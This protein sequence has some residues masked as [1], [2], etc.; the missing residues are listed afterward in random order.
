ML[1][2][3]ARRE[4]LVHL[5][6][7]ANRADEPPQIVAN[8]NRLRLEV[9]FRPRTDL[10]SGLS[11]ALDYSENTRTASQRR[12]KNWGALVPYAGPGSP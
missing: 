1:G 12:M 11:D 2:R 3:L 4:E 7:L 8:V 10:Q 9:G 6:A 5:G